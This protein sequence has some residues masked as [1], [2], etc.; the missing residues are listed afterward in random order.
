MSVK[1]RSELD[2]D[3]SYLVGKT[4]KNII[5]YT[6]TDYLKFTSD[7]ILFFIDDG[8]ILEM[9]HDQEGDEKVISSTDY[10]TCSCWKELIGLEIIKAT[11]SVSKC[12]G[13]EVCL[14]GFRSV[15]TH[16]YLNSKDL[17]ILI[18]WYGYSEGKY[19]EFVDI[20]VYKA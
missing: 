3:I 19:T 10:H 11:K 14:G 16:F 8:Y 13:Y 4:I 20:K 18:P 2:N 7:R 12:V 1:D 17:S 5:R 6:K 15:N 9:F